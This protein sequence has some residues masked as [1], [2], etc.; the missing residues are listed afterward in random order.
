MNHCRGGAGAMDVDWIRVMEN[1]VENEKIPDGIVGTHAGHGNEPSFTRP[2]YP[3]P[4]YAKYKGR[5]DVNQ[6]E[7]FGK[8]SGEPP[9]PNR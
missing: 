6:A 4:D 3:Y 7:N 5:G 8:V 9:T 2:L 1:W